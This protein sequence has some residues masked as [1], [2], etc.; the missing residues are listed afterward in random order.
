VREK[1]YLADQF[2]LIALL[3]AEKWK[4]FKMFVVAVTL[5]KRLTLTFDLSFLVCD[6]Q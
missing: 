2:E 3:L 6:L 4:N 5:R 1:G